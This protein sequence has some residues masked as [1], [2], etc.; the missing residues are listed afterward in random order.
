MIKEQKEYPT[1]TIRITDLEESE[2]PRERLLMQG[3]RA[4]SKTELMAIQLGTGVRGTNALQLAHR[5]LEV[6]DNNLF[7]LYQD[8]KNGQMPPIRGLGEAKKAN[9]L[10][11]LEL[12]IR[13]MHDKE[14]LESKG[15]VLN[16]SKLIYNYIYPDLYNL[17]IE[18]LWLILLNQQAVTQRKIR[19]AVGGI[20]NATADI[21]VILNV[22][23]RLGFPTLALVHNHPGGSTEP[24]S[25][26]DDLTKRL[27]QACELVGITMYDHI[28]FTDNGYYSYFDSNRFCEWL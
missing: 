6:S 10:A 24:S 1:A 21:R 15:E 4:L 27:F 28:I 5:L 23:L 12:G 14:L 19:I 17:S 2:R 16:N 26:D 20:S 25:D 22:A 8:L 9:I 7:T 3:P 18:E 11:C 13:T